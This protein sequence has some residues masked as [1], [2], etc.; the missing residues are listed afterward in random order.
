[1]TILTV[2]GQKTL[3]KRSTPNIGDRDLLL[4]CGHVAR[5]CKLHEPRNERI[6]ELHYLPVEI[7]LELDWN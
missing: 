1:M 4:L 2:P 3:I 7:K 5:I 6:I